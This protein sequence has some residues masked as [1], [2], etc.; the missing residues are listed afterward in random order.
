MKESGYEWRDNWKNA[1]AKAHDVNGK[2]IARGKG[3]RPRVARY[4]AAGGLNTTAKDYTKFLMEIVAP[5]ESDAFRLT[6]AS[7]KEMVRPHVKLPEDQK[8]DGASAWALGWAVHERPEGNLI[9]HSGGQSGYRSLAMASV[10]RKSGFVVLTN[11][12]NGGKVIY[13]PRMMELLGKV[14]E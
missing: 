3:T 2:V 8:I 14:L 9:V 12:D 10:E 11:G 5:K 4:G 6:Q 13:D 7:L 1:F